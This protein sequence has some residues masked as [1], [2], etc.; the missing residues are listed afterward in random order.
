MS[1]FW[2]ADTHFGHTNIIRLCSRPFEDIHSMN[3]Y[4]I[5]TINKK[6]KQNDRLFIL[7]DFSFRGGKPM[8]YLKYIHCENI[9][10]C[11]GNH[12]KE[13]ELYNLLNYGKVKRVDKTIEITHYDQTIF[14][15]HYSHR[16]W[17]KSF[18]G[19]WHC[20]GHTHGRLDQEDQIL[21]RK[22]LDVGV[23]NTTNY[24]KLWGEPWS[25]D[26]LK[27]LM[28]SRKGTINV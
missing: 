17:P 18:H 9:E 5:T 15:S 25:F 12:D 21:Q 16:S 24:G 7:G 14:M 8:E 26:E 27:T 10:F 3:D 4:L 28:D 20:Y 19:S 22:T 1:L 23:D 11:I 13:K 2:T 6:V